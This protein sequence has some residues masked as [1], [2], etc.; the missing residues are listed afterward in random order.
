[1]LTDS[2]CKV[3]NTLYIKCAGLRRLLGPNSWLSLPSL[4]RF[5]VTLLLIAANERNTDQVESP[6][7]MHGDHVT[8]GRQRFRWKESCAS[9]FFALWTTMGLLLNKVMIQLEPRGVSY[10]LQSGLERGTQAVQEQNPQHLTGRVIFPPDLHPI[11]VW[12]ICHL[13]GLGRC[14]G[15]D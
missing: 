12:I 7:V 9:G 4:F 1:M 14:D 13:R 2:T 11:N 6:A 3:G 15:M 8:V 10:C 5:R